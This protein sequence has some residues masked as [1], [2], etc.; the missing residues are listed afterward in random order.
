MANTGKLYQYMNTANQFILHTAEELL[1][2]IKIK[3]ESSHLYR[4]FFIIPFPHYSQLCLCANHK[5]KIQAKCMHTCLFKENIRRE[6]IST[7]LYNIDL[8][9]LSTDSVGDE[10]RRHCVL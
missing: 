2:V 3:G 10:D 6:N 8:S 7:P 4:M 9:L 5:C 1:I